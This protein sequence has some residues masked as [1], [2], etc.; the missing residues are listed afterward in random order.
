M[1]RKEPFLIIDV[2]KIKKGS[3]IKDT[4][5]NSIFGHYFIMLLE[6]PKIERN[7]QNYYLNARCIVFCKNGKIVI[8]IFLMTKN[9]C[10]VLVY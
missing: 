4:L 7:S 6:N 5:T 2:E 8:N 10:D 3:L 1:S 9:L